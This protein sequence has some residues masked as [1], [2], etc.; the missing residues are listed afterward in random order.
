[1][2]CSDSILRDVEQRGILILDDLDAR[3]RDGVQE[4]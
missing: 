3:S 2:Q 4:D 1:M